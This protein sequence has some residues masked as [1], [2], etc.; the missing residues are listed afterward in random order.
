MK[1]YLVTADTYD[2]AWSIDCT[3]YGIATNEQ[4]LDIITKKVEEDGHV[5]Y[6]EEI[7]SDTIVNSQ[8]CF[9]EE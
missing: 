4:S 9:Y 3:C 8:L 1:L 5:A 7:E 6:I 2:K